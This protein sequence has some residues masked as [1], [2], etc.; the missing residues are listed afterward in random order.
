[1]A[2]FGIPHGILGWIRIFSF[3]K[4]KQNIFNYHPWYIN[5]SEKI[6]K[7]HIQFWKNKEKYF[8]VKIKDVSNRSE[9]KKLTNIYVTIKENTLP[10]LKNNEYYWKDIINCTIFNM[11]NK[12]LGIVINL[13]ETPSNDIL[14]INN[15]S[16]SNINN[17][18]IL[19]PFIKNKVIKIVNIN[20]KVIIVNWNY[21]FE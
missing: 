3:T 8:I 5:E 10:L 17:K 4:K 11:E 15:K 21:T 9:A 13:I 14:V 1:M 2:Q 12:K 7:A 16:K 18:N 19:I 6:T 20:K